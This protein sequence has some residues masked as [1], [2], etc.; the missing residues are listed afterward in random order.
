MITKKYNELNGYDNP[1]EKNGATSSEQIN[2][3]PWR[4]MLIVL[5]LL[6]S[7][8]CNAQL[9]SQELTYNNS[10]ARSDQAS[11]NMVFIL[12]DDLG[13]SDLGSYGNGFIE[14][15]AIDKLAKS[16]M[17]FTAAYTAAVCMPSRGMILSGQYNARTGLY[18]VPFKPNDRPWA[19][20]IPPEL[21]GDSPVNAEPLGVLLTRGGYESKIIG[22]IHVPEAFTTG[23]TGKSNSSTDPFQLKNREIFSYPEN[24]EAALG[25][26]FYNKVTEFSEANPGKKVGTIT[27]QAIEFIASN[28]DKPFFLYVGHHI[29][30]IPLVAR[31]ELN[32][33]YEEKWKRNPG[34]IHPHYAAMCEAM[35]ESVGL[36]LESLDQLELSKNT[37]VV[38]FSD[39]GGVF[40]CFA[41]GKGAQITDMS[42]LRGE[43]G[44]I[45]EGGIRV[46]MIVR[47]PG[48]VR[49]NS[50]CDTPV[51]SVDF[52]PTFTEVAGIG[53]PEE[54]LT[55]G[56]SLVPILTEKGQLKNREIF[57]YFPDYH[58]DFPGVAVRQGDYKLI[59][60]SEDGHLELYNLADD[61]G[62]GT[63]L[64]S[65]L[66]EKAAELQGI[67]MNWLERVGARN[68]TPNPDYDPLKAHILNP[69][70][71]QR[72]NDYLPVPLPK[73]K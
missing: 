65:R 14:T 70:E 69:D 68:V 50:V 24:A 32:R 26:S 56:V 1:K 45:L 7:V 53:M 71:E 29:P 22:K 72:R 61:P 27:K 13:W 67:M 23:M 33:K 60:A 48:K 5:F 28:K 58:H 38:F 36:I 59:K 51:V 54:Q 34:K 25:K 8:L 11:P 42:P 41:D 52:L 3:I 20:I 47:W 55:D 66:P 43:K 12:V 64:A 6:N 73:I 35:D 57:S 19:K 44:G 37:M 15:P 49:P 10:P 18:K 62:E 4:S 31:E 30:H 63:N 21:W 40:H 17:R 2:K 46:P 16:G 9:L 39:N